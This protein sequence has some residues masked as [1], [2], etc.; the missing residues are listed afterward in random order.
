MEKG[1]FAALVHRQACSRRVVTYTQRVTN[2]AVVKQG[3]TGCTAQLTSR[4]FDMY[5]AITNILPARAGNTCQLGELKK[6]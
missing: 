5:I 6:L 2:F 3:C 1:I 4:V